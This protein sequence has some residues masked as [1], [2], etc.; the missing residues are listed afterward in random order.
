MA[1]ILGADGANIVSLEQAHRDGSFHTFHLDV[2]VHDVAHLMRSSP[3]CGRR[4]R[5]QLVERI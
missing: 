2:E 4:T 1:G 5:C 3:R